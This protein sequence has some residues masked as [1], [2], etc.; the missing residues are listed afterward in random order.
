MVQRAERADPAAK[1]SPQEQSRY[2]DGQAPEQSPVE[3]AGGER[4]DQRGQRVGLE[5]DADRIGQ[6]R[7]PLA[8]AK[9][10]AK[11]GLEEQKQKQGEEKDLRKQS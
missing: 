1:E 6:P 3:G 11:L 10:A 2:D 8:G 5:E 4:V 9:R 7:L